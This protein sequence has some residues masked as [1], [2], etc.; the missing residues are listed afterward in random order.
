MAR[1]KPVGMKRLWAAA[2]CLAIITIMATFAITVSAQAPRDVPQDHWAYA[3]VNDL[4][5]KGLIRGYPATRDFF[6]GRV[7]SRYEMAVIVLRVLQ[8]IDNRL[9]NKAGKS[10]VKPTDV[11]VKPEQLEEV[12]RLVQEFKTELTVIGT[13]LQKVKDQI[14]EV[15]ASAD[16]AQK[17]A[18]EARAAAGNAS[19]A[20]AA[21]ARAAADAKQGAQGAKDAV[22]E[23]KSRIDKLSET[24]TAHKVSG[25]IQ[26]R[27]DAIDVGRTSLFTS[28]GAGGTGQTPA[29]GAPSVGG[30]LYG[31][32]VRRARINFSGPISK[33]TEYRV[34]LDAQSGNTVSVYDANVLIHDLPVKNAYVR[35]GMF[36]PVFGYELPTPSYVR[37]SPDRVF[38][39]GVTLAD[40]PLFKTNQSATGGVITPGS[41]VGLFVNQQR[42]VGAEFG[43][44]IAGK[45]ND[46][47]KLTLSVING[48]GRSAAG[49]RNLNNG[50]D[51]MGR[52]EAP[53]LDNKLKLGMSGYYGDFAVRSGPPAGSPAVSVP[54]VNAKKTFLG[55][56]VRWLSPWGTSFRLEYFG[57]MYEATPDRAQLLSGNHAQAWYFV[58]RH[59]I[60][61][62]LDVVGKYDEFMPITGKGVMAGG[63]S[64]MEL[65]RKT[66]SI[67]TLYQL[68]NTTRFRLWYAK[69]LTPYDPSATAGPLRTRL[70]LITGE[71]QV[72]F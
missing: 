37:E 67:G 62:K 17:T 54:F 33:Q 47:T 21:A 41:V 26:A 43:W 1:T 59:P 46:K 28:S 9:S 70:G 52:I 42:D 72:A 53:F 30:P 49:V 2:T 66:V 11:G 36:S 22:N 57:G 31:F 64:R 39:W 14:G 7:V 40:Y 38:G 63:L 50:L 6:G 8:Q 44:D 5:S 24:L 60:T 65:I 18:E 61:H 58:A 27:F 55:A 20:A 25:Y 71:V 16:A 10:D 48:E 13:D 4:A 68:D 19:A 45:G 3:V 69:G 12:R 51:V 56:D 35:F 23:Q 34:Q 32:Q 15:S 29:I